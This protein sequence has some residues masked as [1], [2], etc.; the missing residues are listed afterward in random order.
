MIT[1]EEDGSSRS[2]VACKAGTG[3]LMMAHTWKSQG[4]CWSPT[5]MLMNSVTLGKMDSFPRL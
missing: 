1:N 2:S 5:V 4:H 3:G